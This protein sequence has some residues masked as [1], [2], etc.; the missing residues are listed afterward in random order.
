MT[1]FP[2]PAR[3]LRTAF[4]ACASIAGL[5]AVSP[6]ANAGSL[7]DS[8]TCNTA[9][10]SQVFA[11][12]ADPS[13]YYLAPGGDA[14]S[15]AGW[16]LAGGAAV[17]A[18]NEPWNVSGA[19]SSSLSL[20]AGASATSDS[21]CV[22]LE[23]PTVRFFAKSSSASLSSYL[24]VEALFEDATAGVGSVTVGTVSASGQWAPSAPMAIVANLLAL[25]PGDQTAVAVRFTP[26]GGASWMVDDLY[27][28]PYSRG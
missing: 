3:S 9:A 13:N 15:A 5:L 4:V 18:G 14:E 22:G 11:P 12:W 28:D 27:V 21:T 16:S 6:A 20:P 24:R 1:Q 19:G 8:V 25:L 26:V 7:V 2:R 17:L 10:S 23:S